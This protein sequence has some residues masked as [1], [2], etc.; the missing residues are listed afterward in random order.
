MEG[1]QCRNVTRVIIEGEKVGGI[2]APLKIK[3]T[4][5]IFYK[6]LK[7][8]GVFEGHLKN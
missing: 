7:T 4:L 2:L 3:V 5:G 1:W 6:A 8:K